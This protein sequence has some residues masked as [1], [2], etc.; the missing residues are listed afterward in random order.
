MFIRCV[1]R[2]GQHKVL[3]NTD[4]IV[5][6]T[7]TKEGYAKVTFTSR[8]AEVDDNQYYSENE[9]LILNETYEYVCSLIY[10]LGG[11]NGN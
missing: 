6:I 5:N 7:E 4:H 3:I 2:F 10:G 8:R 1:S 11:K 9:T